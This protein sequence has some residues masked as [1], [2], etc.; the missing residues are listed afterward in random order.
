MSPQT[1][2]QC[3]ELIEAQQQRLPPVENDREARS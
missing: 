2:Q 1:A 3:G